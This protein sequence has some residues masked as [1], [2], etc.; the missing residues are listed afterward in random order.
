MSVECEPCTC[1]TCTYMTSLIMQVHSC[2]NEFALE[3][4]N[5]KFLLV[6]GASTVV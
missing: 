4:K 1:K 6:E 5:K 3:K 2:G